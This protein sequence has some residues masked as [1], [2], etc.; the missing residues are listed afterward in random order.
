MRRLFRIMGSSMRHY[1]GVDRK[2]RGRRSHG[3]LE[4]P[5]EA[6]R[7]VAPAPAASPPAVVAHTR[8]SG[9]PGWAGRLLAFLRA[10]WASLHPAGRRAR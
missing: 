2:V 10:L 6:N 9:R 5:Q 7:S 8:P 3:L 4:G 1:G